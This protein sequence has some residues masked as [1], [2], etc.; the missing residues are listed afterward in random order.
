LLRLQLLYRALGVLQLPQLLL[1]LW[2]RQLQLLL[3]GRE[4]L[5]GLQLL[6]QRTS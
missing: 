6:L 5:A 1:Y 2:Q 3:Q 4:Q